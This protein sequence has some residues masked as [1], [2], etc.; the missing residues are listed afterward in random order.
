VYNAISA[1][2]TMLYVSMFDEA[3]E[4]MAMFK[5]VAASQDLPVDSPL[6]A[7]DVDGYNL[8]ADWY[9]LLGGETGKALRGEI[10][11]SPEMPLEFPP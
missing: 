9:L 6:V 11:L 7:L 10:P 3:D 4:G 5:M 2:A 8:P 1:G